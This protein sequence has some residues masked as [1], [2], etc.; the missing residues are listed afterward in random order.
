MMFRDR[1]VRTFSVIVLITAFAALV[2]A[3]GA[4]WD[5]PARHHTAHISSTVGVDRASVFAAHAAKNADDPLPVARTHHARRAHPA[6][7][8]RRAHPA[9]HARI[10][11]PRSLAARYLPAGASLSDPAALPS[12]PWA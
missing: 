7:H 4:E 1:A 2:G 8:A 10:V 11:L 3:A 9:K 5:A 6:K 12:N